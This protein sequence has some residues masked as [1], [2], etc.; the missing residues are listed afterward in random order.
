MIAGEFFYLFAP[1][2]TPVP[3][4]QQS[5][6]HRARGAR[7]TTNSRRSSKARASIRCSRA[8]STTRGGCSRPSAPAGCRSP[9]PPAPRS[10]RIRNRMD[11]H[12]ASGH[13]GLTRSTMQARRGRDRALRGR[14]RTAAPLSCTAAAGSCPTAPFLAR[15]LPA[16]PRDRAGASGLRRVEPADLDRLGRR[17]RAPLSR[18]D[19]PARS[20]RRRCWSAIRSAAGPRPRSQPRARLRSTSSC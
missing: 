19:R 16:L 17:L 6:R 8:G 10:T 5:E 15:A 1:A 2:G 14:Q 12:D 9:K 20:L 18:T 13:S 3:I 7:P 4:L 11:D